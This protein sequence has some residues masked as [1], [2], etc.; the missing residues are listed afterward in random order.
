MRCGQRKARVAPSVALGVLGS[1]AGGCGPAADG[2]SSESGESG[3]SSSTSGFGTSTGTSGISSS[4]ANDSSGNGTTA[5]S[6]DGGTS[7]TTTT[8]DAGNPCDPV[9]FPDPYVE[10][11]VRAVTE[12]P[13]GPIGGDAVAALTQLNFP[14]QTPVEDLTGL[15]CAINLE[16]FNLLVSE[17]S[18]VT[19]LSGLTKMRRLFI[20]GSD[21]EDISPLAGM[22]E[23]TYV[24]LVANR[25]SDISAIAQFKKAHLIEL[26]DND[27]TDL[28]PL[29]GAVWTPAEGCGDILL[30]GNPLMQQTIDEDLPQLCETSNMAFWHDAAVCNENS[31]SPPFKSDEF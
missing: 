17:I 26:D 23:L 27:V 8:E 9:E 10:E 11:L 6:S 16:E 12:I 2:A 15:E 22:T 20:T 24:D 28:A 1:V 5:S 25:I 4:G 14:A 18:D 3:A 7:S 30:W 29:L 21:V 31:C 19:P 13:T